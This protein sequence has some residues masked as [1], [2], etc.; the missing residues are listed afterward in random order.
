MSRVVSEGGGAKAR[1]FVFYLDGVSPA[2][3]SVGDQLGGRREALLEGES[4]GGSRC[5]AVWGDGGGGS[6]SRG[7][8]LSGHNGMRRRRRAAAGSGVENDLGLGGLQRGI[9]GTVYSTLLLTTTALLLPY[10]AHTN[11]AAALTSSKP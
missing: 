6:G 1:C 8:I 3:G 4:L 2:L 5:Q 9:G 10:A 7:D 11:A